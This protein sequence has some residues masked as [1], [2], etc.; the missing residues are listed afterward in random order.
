MNWDEN[1]IENLTKALVFSSD[2]LIPVITQDIAGTVLMQAWMDKT[3]IQETL[4]TGRACYWSR[5]R[6]RLWR[7][8]ETSGQW[9]DV[10]SLHTDCDRDSLLLTVKQHGVACH[11]G[12]RRCFYVQAT[13]DGWIDAEPVITDPTSL[14]PTT[15]RLLS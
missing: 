8:G 1:T 5:S 2:G 4:R 9:Q 15:T 13:P 6:K 7:K 11:T 14:Y 10:V 3:A 12:R